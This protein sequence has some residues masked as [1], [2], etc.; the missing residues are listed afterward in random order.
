MQSGSIPVEVGASQ[1]QVI[2]PSRHLHTKHEI[3]AYF[4][5]SYKSKVENIFFPVG[6][7]CIVTSY[8]TSNVFWGFFLS[9][10][11]FI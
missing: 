10:L 6:I 4:F 1:N 11:A 2:V 7:L 9:C 8:F 5:V 3:C